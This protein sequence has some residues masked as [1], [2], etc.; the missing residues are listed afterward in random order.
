MAGFLRA[1]C[2]LQLNVLLRIRPLPAAL[3][4]PLRSEPA[5]LGLLKSSCA[6]SPSLSRSLESVSCNSVR[7]DSDLG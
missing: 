1:C 5:A 4:D 2:I 7:S 3:S 6:S